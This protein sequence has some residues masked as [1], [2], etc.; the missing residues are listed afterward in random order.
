MK[1]NLLFYHQSTDITCLC[2]CVCVCVWVCQAPAAQQK[3]P[4]AL[5]RWLVN[6]D[7]KL[8]QQLNAAPGEPQ[9]S[10]LDKQCQ[11]VHAAL[12]KFDAESGNKNSAHD[13]DELKKLLQEKFR[14]LDQ[15]EREAKEAMG[16]VEDDA[17]GNEIYKKVL[18][19][20]D[21]ERRFLKEAFDIY[22]D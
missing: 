12:H 7:N 22:D 2:V 9:L 18:A 1:W 15:Q 11:L 17:A 3:P 16:R 20:I 10:Q 14:Q 21:R 19:S 5:R 4:P 13:Q 6:I 8:S